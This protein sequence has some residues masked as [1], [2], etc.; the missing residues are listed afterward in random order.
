MKIKLILR[1]CPW[2]RK[3]PD[4]WMPIQEETWQWKI[5]CINPDCGMKPES[6]H[7]SIRK[8][9]KKEFYAFHG[10]VERLCSLWNHNNPFKAFE[11][12]IINLA[13]LPE[14]V[15]SAALMCGG[16]P[17]WQTIGEQ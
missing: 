1:P 4:I 16:D 7:V 10:K 3:T 2:C 9:N 6:P 12:K 14:L 15:V 5:K 8:S 13:S 17:W 11:A